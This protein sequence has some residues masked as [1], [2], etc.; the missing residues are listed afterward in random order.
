MANIDPQQRSTRDLYAEFCIRLE[1]WCP[2]VGIDGPIRDASIQITDGTCR[3]EVITG[4]E[5][6]PIRLDTMTIDGACVGTVFDDFDCVPNVIEVEGAAIMVGTFPPRPSVLPDLIEAL[7]D[8]SEG[9]QLLRLISLDT[10]RDHPVVIDLSM[11][12]EKERTAI[13]EAVATGYFDSNNEVTLADISETLDIS[14]SA[15]SKQLNSAKTK[16]IKQICRKD[17][18]TV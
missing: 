9:V 8:V 18:P 13:Q 10:D 3:A 4:R 7:R 2:L 17:E 16:V 11:L 6:E 14:E 5:P 12:S 15:V 1:E